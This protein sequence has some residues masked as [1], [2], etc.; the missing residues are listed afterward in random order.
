MS[1]PGQCF[2][3]LAYTLYR[4]CVGVLYTAAQARQKRKDACIRDSLA[5]LRCRVLAIYT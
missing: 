5:C 3:L 2:I 4:K 1:W